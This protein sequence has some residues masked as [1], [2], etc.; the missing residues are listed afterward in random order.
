MS[1]SNNSGAFFTGFLLG[2]L[3]GAAAALLMTPES[4]EK[5]RI[6]LQ[7]RSIELKTKFDDL[8]GGL[9]ERGGVI[10]EETV[11]ISAEPS[12]EDAAEPPTEAENDRSTKEPSA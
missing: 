11:P 9:Q 1:S 10:V 5:T 7:Q 2:G 6:R 12:G 3:V 8:S 4:G